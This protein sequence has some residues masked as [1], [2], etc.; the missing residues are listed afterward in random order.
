M[1]EKEIKDKKPNVDNS[2]VTGII[3]GLVFMAIAILV[4]II[5]S[6][7]MGW[8]GDAKIVT[9]VYYNPTWKR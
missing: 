2:G 4:M 5:L 6:K 9:K 8:E 1:E 3:S 7:Y